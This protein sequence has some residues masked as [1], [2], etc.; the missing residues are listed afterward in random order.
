MTSDQATVSNGG[1]A[2]S[3]KWDSPLN[4]ERAISFSVSSR[5]TQLKDGHRQVACHICNTFAFKYSVSTNRKHG[6]FWPFKD[7]KKITW[8]NSKS[9]MRNLFIFRNNLELISEH[10][11]DMVLLQ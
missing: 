5:T 7:A 9:S 3:G 11:G 2:S 10:N 8:T 6:P 4:K 1:M